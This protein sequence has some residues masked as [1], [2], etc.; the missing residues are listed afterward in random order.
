MGV[1]KE[2]T[3]YSVSQEVPRKEIFIDCWYRYKLAE[4]L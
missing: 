4:L 3:N 2:I 1:I